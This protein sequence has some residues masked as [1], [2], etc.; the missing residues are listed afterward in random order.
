MELNI[1][2]VFIKKLNPLLFSQGKT[3]MLQVSDVCEF[4]KISRFFIIF[5]FF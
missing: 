5:F 4:S 2:K 3:F 1:N